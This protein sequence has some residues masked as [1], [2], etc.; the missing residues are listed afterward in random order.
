MPRGAGLA[1]LFAFGGAGRRRAGRRR[2][3][4]PDDDLAT[5]FH[6]DITANEDGSLDVAE[7]ITWH[8]PQGEERHGIER[9]VTVRVGYQDREDTYREYPLTDVT[10]TSPSGAPADVSV[11][12]ATDGASMRI[13][14]GR[15]DETVRAPRPTSCATTSASTS[16]VSPTTPSSTTTWSTPPTTTS[17]R[18]SAPP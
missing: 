4:A 2:A 18:T 14:V 11:T 10:V 9:Y 5:R 8:F 17:T 16:T 15:A 13:R 3:A 12:D 6:V 1:V 7:N